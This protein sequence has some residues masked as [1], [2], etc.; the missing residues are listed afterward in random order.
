MPF[1]L[2]SRGGDL[3][4][5]GV[6]VALAAACF[7][8]LVADPGALVVDG[9]RPSIDYANTGEP[10]P[11]G[12]DATFLFL[13]HHRSISDTIARFGHVPLWDARGFGGRPMVGNPQGGMFYPPVWLAWWSGAPAALGWLT[14]GHLVWGGLGVYVAC[15]WAGQ[16][17]WAATAAAGTYQASPLLLAHTFEGHYPHVWAACWFPWAFWAFAELRAGAK[18]GLVTLPLILAIVFLT[19]H[20]QEWLFLIVALSSWAVFD[21]WH[22]RRPRGS[23]RRPG[24][25]FISIWAGIVALALGLTSVEL[26]PFWSVRPWL[27][28]NHDVAGD[29]ELPTRHHLS[30]LNGLQLL[31]PQALG[32]PA[33]YFGNDNYWETV[34]SIGFVP[35]VCCA[36][37]LARHPE[38]K[39]VKGWAAL[40][41]LSVWFACGRHLGF[42]T[43]IYSVVPGMSSL[44]VPARSLF[45]GNLAAAMLT[46]FGVESFLRAD[47]RWCRRFATRFAVVAVVIVGFLAVAQLGR[48]PTQPYIRPSHRTPALEVHGRSSPEKVAS[49]TAPAG[50]PSVSRL[51]IA[52]NRV[53]HDRGFWFALC[54]TAAVIGVGS[55]YPGKR[56]QHRAFRLIGLVALIELGFSGFSLL[57]TAPAGT[58]VSANPLVRLNVAT[59]PAPRVKARDSVYGDLAA[60]VHGIEKININDYFQVEHASALYEMLYT[61]ASHRRPL[62]ESMITRAAEDSRRLIRQAVFDRMSVTHLVSDRVEAGPGWPVVDDALRGGS[63]QVVQANPSVM[64]RAYVVPRATIVP[65]NAAVMLTSFAEIDARQCVLMSHDPLSSIAPGARQ[66][67]TLAQWTSADPDCPAFTITTEAPSLLVVTDTWMPGWSARVDDR[68]VAVLRGNHAQRVI[69]LVEPGRHTIVMRYRPPGLAVGLMISLASLAAWCVFCGLVIFGSHQRR[70]VVTPGP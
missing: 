38:R 55:F 57:Q 67:F 62:A 6:L 15:R 42:F 54:A 7:G 45:L 44:R 2:P 36:V 24:R 46:G 39:Q 26:V 9:L 59:M 51:A 69:P 65:E 43:L 52:A 32:G 29:T 47:R 17:R 18:V 56:A 68:P 27:R 48:S 28:G 35:L 34:L 1:R 5:V 66:P 4:A 14:V 22:G 70:A 8:R 40:L 16:G 64:P 21:Q 49:K 3:L 60:A 31:S 30:A 10:R 61:V 11:I 53:L 63:R 13:P 41:T 12:N 33:D 37:A 23:P 58:F 20:P 19:G 25:P 50:H